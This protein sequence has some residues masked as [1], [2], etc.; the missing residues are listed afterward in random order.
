M[1]ITTYISCVRWDHT[2][3]VV[4]AGV[5]RPSVISA[6]N[7]QGFLGSD[8]VF[9]CD[10]LQLH[11]TSASHGWSFISSRCRKL[12]GKKLTATPSHNHHHH[13][14]TVICNCGRFM[15]AGFTLAH[16]MSMENF[17][18]GGFPLPSPRFGIWSI[19]L[20]WYDNT[21]NCFT[22]TS[23]LALKAGGQPQI[24]SQTL[25]DWC[26]TVLQDKCTSLSLIHIWRCRRS[27]AC[28]SRWSPYH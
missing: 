4:T 15:T 18:R 10:A 22:G 16:V 9:A 8:Q 3:T 11:T 25:E 28:R 27:Y 14:S 13:P 24:T 23:R 17:S 12:G 2:G 20:P 1:F 5:R 26:I 19:I 21:H 7:L 6:S